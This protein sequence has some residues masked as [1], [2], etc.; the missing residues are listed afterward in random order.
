VVISSEHAGSSGPTG[1]IG[2]VEPDAPARAERLGD[3]TA[4]AVLGSGS[5]N[6]VGTGIETT[7][8]TALEAAGGTAA[9]AGPRRTGLAARTLLRRALPALALYAG[10]RLLG[11]VVLAIWAGAEGRS[12][13]QL[14]SARWDSLWYSDIAAHGYHW[15]GYQA[16]SHTRGAGAHSHLAFFPLLPWLE[17]GLNAVT[18]LSYADAGLLVSAVASVA[19]ALGI[20][21]VGERIAGRRAATLLVVLWAAL[22]IGVL[23][24]M[25]YTESLFT[26]LAAWSLWAVLRGNWLTAGPLAALAGLTRPSAAAVVA[27]VWAAA[28]VALWRREGSHLRIL[29]SA[30]L[31]PAGLLGYAG[32][33]GGLSGYLA[34]QGQWGNGF[35]FGAAYT[36]FIGHH[37]ATSPLAGAG[38][39][40]FVGLV[41]WS[42][43]ACLR[44]R[45]RQPLPVVVYSAVIVALALGAQ[46]YFNSKPRLLMPAFPLLLPL[47]AWLARVQVTRAV[48]ALGA[49]ALVSAA[50]GTTC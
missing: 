48:A 30:A 5:E 45:P 28:A 26:A 17:R 41:L 25:A 40:V 12:P 47:A 20:F 11:V 2:S 36:R 37:L 33:V 1:T 15:A 6:A 9:V 22:P 38:L 31:A 29:A 14:L 46:A 35:D 21:A 16:T 32:W 49:L 10:V 23:Q 27:V 19:A 42:L 43:W 50:Y 7:D 4:E 24:S 3:A 8:G 13:H 18:R 44:Q 34:V 39:L